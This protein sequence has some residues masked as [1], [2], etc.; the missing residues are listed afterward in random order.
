[1]CKINNE[2]RLRILVEKQEGVTNST[3]IH[4]CS[5]FLSLSGVHWLLLLSQTGSKNLLGNLLLYCII[6]N[7]LSAVLSFARMDAT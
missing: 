3:F 5:R 1:M 7:L 4:Y 6:A 2:V